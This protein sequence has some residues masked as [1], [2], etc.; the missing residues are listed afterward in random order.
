MKATKKDL[1]KHFPASYTHSGLVSHFDSEYQKIFGFNAHKSD[2]T[3]WVCSYQRLWKRLR[4]KEVFLTAKASKSWLD[5]EL[6]SFGNN[7]F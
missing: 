2:L 1:V 5:T 4:N 7:D 3:L 6:P